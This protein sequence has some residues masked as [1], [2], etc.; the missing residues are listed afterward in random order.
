MK[1]LTEV[2]KEDDYYYQGPFWIVSDSFDAMMQGK[3]EILGELILTDFFG[4]YKDTTHSKRFYIH[5]TLWNTEKYKSIYKDKPYN[6]YPRGRVVIRN[7]K[8]Y[9]NI[10]SLCNNPKVIDK[11]VGKYELKKLPYTISYNDSEGSHYDFLMQ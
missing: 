2:R 7:G 4:V 1:L 6:Y 8:A 3:F 5:K 9:I 11:I 10:N